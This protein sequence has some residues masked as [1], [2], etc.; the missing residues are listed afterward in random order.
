MISA[1]TQPGAFIIC[2]DDNPTSCQLKHIKYDD[3]LDGLKKGSLYT[4]RS[5]EIWERSISGF[6]VVVDEINRK[7]D[8]QGFDISRF[9]PAILPRCLT[10]ILTSAKLHDLVD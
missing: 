1:M 7:R 9:K 8:P 3:D 4:V 2:I 5:I 6:I 10:S